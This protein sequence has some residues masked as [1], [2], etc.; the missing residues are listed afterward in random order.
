[1]KDLLTIQNTCSSFLIHKDMLLDY[2]L[3]TSLLQSVRYSSH[4][5]ILILEDIDFILGPNKHEMDSDDDYEVTEDASNAIHALIG[6]AISKAIKLLVQR[7]AKEVSYTG[8]PH[9]NHSVIPSPLILG[10][11]RAPLSQL[12]KELRL[13]E[14]EIVMPPPNLS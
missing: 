9:Q 7:N 2:I 10:I 4:W 6:N 13:F 11:S 1:M 3:P 5:T 14:K 8:Y 12:P